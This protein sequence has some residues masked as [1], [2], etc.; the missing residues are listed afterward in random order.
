[1]IIIDPQAIGPLW[2]YDMAML[3]VRHL[4]GLGY[5]GAYVGVPGA[6]EEGAEGVGEDDWNDAVAAVMAEI[7]RAMRNE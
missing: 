4:R 1:M 7:G 2:T 6:G 5:A 3:A